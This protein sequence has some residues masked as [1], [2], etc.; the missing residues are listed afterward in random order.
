MTNKQI[1]STIR[2]NAKINGLVFKKSETRLNE[3]YLW[4]LNDRLTGQIVMSNYQLM[5]AWSDYLNGYLAT[6]NNQTR[7]F[8]GVR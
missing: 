3:S 2:R 5:T 8:E 1:I 6:Y 4:Q 7:F